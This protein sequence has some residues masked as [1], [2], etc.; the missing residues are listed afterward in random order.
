[1]RLG[2]ATNEGGVIQSETGTVMTGSLVDP[3]EFVLPRSIEEVWAWALRANPPATGVPR[4]LNGAAAIVLAPFC[5]Q[6]IPACRYL[7]N[8]KILLVDR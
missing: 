2:K 7:H 5:S 6:R 4:L 8:I 1:M 3:T